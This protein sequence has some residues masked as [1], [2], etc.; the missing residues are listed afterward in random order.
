VFPL[1]QQWLSEAAQKDAGVFSGYQLS[2]VA[3][4]TRQTGTSNLAPKTL[5]N[6]LIFTAGYPGLALAI[7]FIWL[8]LFAALTN[9][10]DRGRGAALQVLL[11]CTVAVALSSYASGL[12]EYAVTFF[13]GALL[14]H[15]TALAHRPVPTKA[16]RL[17]QR[18]S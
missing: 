18:G 5:P 6:L 13:L 15:V 17:R 3:E 9:L 11:V 16:P 10:A 14:S 8:M 7:A 4:L 1:E 2:E 12:Y